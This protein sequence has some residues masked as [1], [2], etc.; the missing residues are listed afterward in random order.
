MKLSAD[1]NQIISTDAT[2]V[3]TVPAYATTNL[4]LAYKIKAGS[5]DAEV[6][7][8]VQNLF[9]KIG[10]P[11]NFQ[12]SQVNIGLFGGFAIGDDPVGRYFAAGFKL[13]F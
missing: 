10:P 4:N 2:K 5:G 6:F 9:D 7:F 3:T 12:G 1:P 11:A 13:K 8:N